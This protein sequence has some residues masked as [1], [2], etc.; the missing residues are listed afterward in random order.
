MSSE[1]QDYL[2]SYFK[3]ECHIDERLTSVHIKLKKRKIKI[4]KKINRPY[5]SQMLC[6]LPSFPSPVYGLA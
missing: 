3:R 5:N 6:V 2:R 1:H 4:K